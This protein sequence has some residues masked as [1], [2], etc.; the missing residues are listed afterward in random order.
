MLGFLPTRAYRPGTP[1]ATTF[2]SPLSGTFNYGWDSF[3]LIDLPHHAVDE[4][5]S[6]TL[7]AVKAGA[8][9]VFEASFLEHRTFVAVD[10]LEHAAE[11]YHLIEVKSST[12]QKPEH[13]PDVGV[14]FNIL[15]E[16]GIN[17]TRASVMHLNRD[18]RSPDLGDRFSETDVTTEAA[19][20]A[21]GAATRIDAQLEMLDGPI[22]SVAIR[23]PSGS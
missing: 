3:L 1:G 2:L 22:P 18:F 19:E 4:R 9:A 10:I 14:Q 16:A 12:S 8:P 5:I 17:V 7:E 21:L 11:G 20:F 6:Q 15:A 23:E 13:I